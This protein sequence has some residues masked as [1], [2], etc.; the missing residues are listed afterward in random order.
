MLYEDMRKLSR[1]I[2]VPLAIARTEKEAE[3]WE[4]TYITQF[5]KRSI[6]ENYPNVVIKDLTPNDILNLSREFCY[7]ILL[8]KRIKTL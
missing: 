6:E 2:F 5:V 1:A 8:I 3:E 7:N 4:E